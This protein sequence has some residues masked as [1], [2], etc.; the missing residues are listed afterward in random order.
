MRG[1]EPALK[2]TE[3]GE[4]LAKLGSV[5]VVGR[6]G[7][8]VLNPRAGHPQRLGDAPGRFAAVRLT[9]VTKHAAHLPGNAASVEGCQPRL[10]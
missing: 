8:Q 5:Q 2:I 4:H 7:V 3:C 1:G 6:R 9:A 10:N